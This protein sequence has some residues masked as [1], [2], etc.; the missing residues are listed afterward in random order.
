MADDIAAMEAQ[1]ALMEQQ[2]ATLKALLAAP[3]PEPAEPKKAR[4]GKITVE[5][6]GP[7][8]GRKC[9]TGSTAKFKAKPSWAW[10]CDT[11]W[12]TIGREWKDE[13]LLA[14]T[15]AGDTPE[16]RQ[17]QRT[18]DRHTSYWVAGPNGLDIRIGLDGRPLSKVHR[19]WWDRKNMDPKNLPAGWVWCKRF[20]IGLKSARDECSECRRECG[21]HDLVAAREEI[22]RLEA[23]IR[24][25]A[26]EPKRE[27]LSDK[28]KRKLAREESARNEAERQRAILDNVGTK[29]QFMCGA[30]KCSLADDGTSFWAF[31]GKRWA[32]QIKGKYELEK[33]LKKRCP[34]CRKKGN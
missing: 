9:P 28:E 23:E 21:L 10:R 7:S 20:L 27:G 2:E 4:A 34:D 15:A 17:F 30:C 25:A 22:K 18:L 3:D 33:P 12:L 16:W 24:E 8:A 11:C 26:P 6:T 13:H 5:C 32:V 29:P 14:V 19:E 31:D 1:L